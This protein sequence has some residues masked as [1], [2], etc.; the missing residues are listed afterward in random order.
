MITKIKKNAYLDSDKKCFILGTGPSLADTPLDLLEDH[1]TIGV[2]LILN[3]GFVPNYICVSDRDMIHDNYNMIIS[4]KMKN[5]SYL[6]V[7]PKNENTLNKLK[8]V[9]NVRFINGFKEPGNGLEG[10]LSD[11]KPFID[12]NLNKFAMTKN[13][14]INDMAISL[15]IY[16]GFKEINLLGV[17]GQHGSNTHFYDH[18]GIE[19]KINS[20]VRESATVTTY[21]LLVPMLKE[22]GIKLYN[23][24]VHGN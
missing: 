4:N 1:I 22:K 15:A 3:S 23:C 12:E 24:S 20:I 10:I 21:K 16:L 7:K 18:H 8:E 13:G 14:V 11:R 6:I 5:G 2:N 17:D 19:K 9:K